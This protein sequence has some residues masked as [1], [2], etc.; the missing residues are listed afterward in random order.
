MTGMKRISALFLLLPVALCSLFFIRPR[1]V[2]AE[3]TYAYIPNANVAFYSDAE[4][5]ARLLLFY[6]PES[7]F[8]CVLSE[9]DGFYRVSYLE[10]TGS[11]KRLTGYVEA[12]CVIPVTFTPEKPY[13]DKTIEVTYY[14]SGYADLSG[15]LLSRI[16]LTC[17]YY[18]DYSENGKNYCYVLRG[19]TFGYVERPIGFTYTK[20]TEYSE[21]TVSEQ[22]AP[23]ATE[24]ETAG[25]SPAQIVFLV[26]LC[27][28]IPTLAAL[29]LHPSRKKNFP[30]DD[31]LN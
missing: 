13:L 17:A 11:A 28:L 19:D 30:D 16:T 24:E 15:N 5:A 22:L 1:T 2:K 7:Y 12:S 25:L 31:S 20:N 10:D 18:G 8:V 3:T 29:I 9:T 23:A 21:K 27:L 14:T 26:L 4:E 6:L